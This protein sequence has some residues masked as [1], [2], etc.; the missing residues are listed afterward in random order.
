ME[1]GCSDLN[2]NSENIMEFMHELRAPVECLH[3]RI[4]QIQTNLNEVR[5]VMT[6]STNDLI[7]CMNFFLIFK[8]IDME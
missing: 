7:I 5:D 6:V 3:S 1:I 4:V 8:L 2:W